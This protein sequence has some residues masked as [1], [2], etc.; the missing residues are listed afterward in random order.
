MEGK[1]EI[2]STNYLAKGLETRD[3]IATF[4]SSDDRLGF[5]DLLTEFCLREACTEPRFSD[6]IT[7]FHV[8]MIVHICY[9]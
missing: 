4:P 2:A 6:Q 8:A 1:V 9:I 3:N 7:T 5:T